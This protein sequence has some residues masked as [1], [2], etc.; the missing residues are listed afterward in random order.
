MTQP[1][2]RQLEKLT[3]I[4]GS[5][6]I[7]VL[8]IVRAQHAGGLWRDECAALQLARMPGFQDIA[9]NF[10]HEAF[11]LLFP[12][13]IRSVTDLFGTTDT[14]LRC[15]GLFVGIVLIAAGWFNARFVTGNVPLVFLTLVGL[16]TT[17]LT[18]ASS[19]RGYG[20][21]S[22]FIILAFGF[23]ARLLVEVTWPRIILAMMVCLASVQCLL[24]NAALVLAINGS[25]G[26][27][28]LIRRDF[29]RAG[30]ILGIGLISALS[31]L[32]YVGSYERASAWN[33]VVKSPVSLEK[34]WQRLFSVLG[35][36]FPGMAWVWLILGAGLLAAAAWRLYSMRHGRPRP[37]WDTLLFVVCALFA[38]LIATYVFFQILGYVPQPWYYV[39]LISVLGTALDFLGAL[40]LTTKLL[41]IGRLCLAM[42]GLVILPIAAWPKIIQRQTNIDIAAREL[43]QS[44]T[45]N[46]LIVVSPWQFGIPFSWYYHG[47]TRWI[48][49][50]SLSDHRIH[51]YD[52]LKEKMISP[53]PIDEVLIL[54]RDALRAGNQVWLVGGMQFPPPGQAP[55]V[56]PPAP[57]STFGWDNVAYMA[58]WDQQMSAFVRAHALRGRPVIMPTNDTVV[59]MLESVPVFVVQGWKE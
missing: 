18:W 27:I 11:P 7:L 25:A 14:V 48:T 24:H 20:L 49:L 42:M 32:P 50:P 10:Q 4:A 43:D 40:L 47:A 39:A 58:S 17:I 5:V 19:I 23:V 1:S 55:L 21:G 46:D 26:A 8:L 57:N 35:T 52:L 3:A 12:A 16:N 45:S 53:Q 59:N 15:F 22:V 36:P 31:L 34:V 29:K 54:I 37:E 56:L 44:A 38:S 13:V 33:V 9:Q 28:C 51:R 30:F 41:R 2:I 6:T